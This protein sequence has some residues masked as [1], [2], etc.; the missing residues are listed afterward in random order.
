M[1]DI[2]THSTANEIAIA[3][4][5]IS[6]AACKYMQGINCFNVGNMTKEQWDGLIDIVFTETLSHCASWG[7]WRKKMHDQGCTDLVED[8]NY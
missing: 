2:K 1:I 7:V 3:K 5:D 8:I 6:N 4:R